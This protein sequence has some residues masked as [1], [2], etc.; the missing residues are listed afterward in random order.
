MSYFSSACNL[1][2]N[3]Y[4]LYPVSLCQE[5]RGLPARLDLPP[6]LTLPHIIPQATQG[7]LPS[8]AQSSHPGPVNPQTLYSP[9]RLSPG[10]RS[11]RHPRNPLLAPASVFIPLHPA[12]LA[13]HLAKWHPPLW[14]MTHPCSYP[15]TRNARI[16]SMPLSYTG[17]EIYD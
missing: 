8:R 4:L 6:S 17:L 3:S 14:L 7:Q 9:P 16:R 1:I 11:L 2:T 10:L 5:N 12:P 13:H 15:F